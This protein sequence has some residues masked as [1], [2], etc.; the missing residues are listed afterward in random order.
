LFI[1]IQSVG[2]LVYLIGY[3]QGW[4]PMPADYHSPKPDNV[5]IFGASMQIGMFLIFLLIMFLPAINRS[6]GDRRKGVNKFSH[7]TY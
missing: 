1:P 2:N 7:S 5:D 3:N 6:I 4:I